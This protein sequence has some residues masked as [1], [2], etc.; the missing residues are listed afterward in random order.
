[1]SIII[2]I[3]NKIKSNGL[4]LMLY[5]FIVILG[6]IIITVNSSSAK[7]NYIYNEF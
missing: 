2:A 1:M 5:C 7:V 6:V 4:L 3:D